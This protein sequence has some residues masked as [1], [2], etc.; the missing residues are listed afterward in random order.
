MEA[1]EVVKLYVEIAKL[2]IPFTVVFWF[3]EMITTT[4]LRAALG[5]RLSF[6]VN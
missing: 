1:V 4:V 2:A 5:G 3:C 6:K